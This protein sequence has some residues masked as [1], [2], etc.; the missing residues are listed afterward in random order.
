VCFLARRASEDV[1]YEN[2]TDAYN[3]T[4]MKLRRTLDAGDVFLE[5]NGEGAGARLKRSR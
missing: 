1:V 5:A 4:L 2:G 3:E